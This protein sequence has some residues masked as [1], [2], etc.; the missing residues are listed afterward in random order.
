MIAEK[1]RGGSR[2]KE[3]IVQNYSSQIYRKKYQR[4]KKS[5]HPKLNSNKNSI[6]KFRI[7]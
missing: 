3:K 6:K 1:K 4:V 5:K 7:F 2:T